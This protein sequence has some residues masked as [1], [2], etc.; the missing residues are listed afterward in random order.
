M[1]KLMSGIV[2]ELISVSLRL[3]TPW[4]LSLNAGRVGNVYSDFSGLYPGNN[5]S[6]F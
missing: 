5:I 4:A 1:N 3:T 2:N 6:S